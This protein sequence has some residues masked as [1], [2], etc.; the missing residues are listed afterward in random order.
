M[1]WLFATTEINHHEVWNVEF[2]CRS[3]FLKDRL[4]S[5]PN[6]P[7]QFFTA[8]WI[9]LRNT[10]VYMYYL[11]WFSLCA[12]YRQEDWDLVW[13][14]NKIVIKGIRKTDRF[15]C[16][17][18]WTWNKLVCTIFIWWNTEECSIKFENCLTSTCVIIS[19]IFVVLF[20]IVCYS[21]RIFL[22]KQKS[23]VLMLIV[24]L[25]YCKSTNGV[26]IL[27]CV[28]LQKYQWEW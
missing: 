24:F 27:Y 5:I 26:R 9:C 14:S 19:K 6:Y 1:P 13:I 8:I 12:Q 2:T 16:L 17:E 10:Y 4:V 7:I 20:S 21:V 15:H 23:A 22:S 3:L 18:R 25:F 11:Y 28:L